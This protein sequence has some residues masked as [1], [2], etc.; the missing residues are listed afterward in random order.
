[1][2]DIFLSV[3]PIIQHEGSQLS[4]AG[5]ATLVECDKIP[6]LITAA[7]VLKKNGSEHPLY[8]GIGDKLVSIEYT[9]YISKEK[10]GIDIDIAVFDVTLCQLLYD[11][12]HAYGMKTI[13]LNS[14]ASLTYHT[15]SNYM[16]VGFPW[17]KSKYKRKENTL[18]I[19][20]FQYISDE[21]DCT[22]YEK[23]NR[24]KDRF[25]L[26]DYTR[27]KNK[28]FNGVIKMGP[29]PQGSSGGALL[30]VLS[31]EKNEIVMSIFE[32][33][34]IEWQ[35]EEHIVATKKSAIIDF[36]ILSRLCIRR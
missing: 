22:F 8:L 16:A 20:S 15:Q 34:L 26:V 9:A 17:R 27:K 28:D 30:K 23:Y 35:N 32:G 19:K 1:M 36:L 31:D 11:E 2:E 24:P 12:L 13:S 21:A 14:P 18:N 6:F 29:I 33:I 4:I 5:T 3:F 10:D 7:H 25:L